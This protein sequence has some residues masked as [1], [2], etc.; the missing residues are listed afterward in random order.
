[1]S[2][3]R[4]H[5]SLWGPPILVMVAIFAFSAM[6][7]DSTDHGPIVFVLRKI[8]H[9]SEYAI[10]V[11]LLWRAARERATGDRA[12]IAAYALTVAYAGTDEFHQT[13]VS[14]R[15][16]TWRDV[17]IDASGAAVAVLVI[18]HLTRNRARVASRA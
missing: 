13:F 1:M 16:G 8:A 12:L 6:P 14:G 7:S 18:R 15:V 17:V 4:A 5:F 9:F 10:L 3:S 11:A 2:R